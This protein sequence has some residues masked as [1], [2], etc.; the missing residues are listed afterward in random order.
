VKGVLSHASGLL[1]YG[2][3]TSATPFH[4]GTLCVAQPLRRTGFQSSGGNPPPVDCSGV[5]TLDFNARI[6][7]GTDPALVAGTIVDAQ[8]FYRDGGDPSGVG[9]SDALHFAIEN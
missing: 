9:L 1:S 8:F 7:S 4:G 3:G 5:L 2:L 6:Q